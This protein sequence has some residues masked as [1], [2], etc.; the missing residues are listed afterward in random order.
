[1][2]ENIIEAEFPHMAQ[3]YRES[4]RVQEVGRW[5]YRQKGKRV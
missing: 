4:K 5:C 2:L 1:M 3:I